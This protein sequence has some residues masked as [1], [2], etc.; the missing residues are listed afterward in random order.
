M[1]VEH[2][3]FTRDLHF[4]YRPG[5]DS[6]GVGIPVLVGEKSLLLF[7]LKKRVQRQANE[8]RVVVIRAYAQIN[9][10]E[11]VLPLRKLKAAAVEART[12]E[13]S[14]QCFGS[15]SAVCLQS[16]RPAHRTRIW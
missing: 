14:V 12:T 15:L 4:I 7:F 9:R 5:H 2:A 3:D 13:K 1:K 8:A 6:R 11:I 16:L 10:A